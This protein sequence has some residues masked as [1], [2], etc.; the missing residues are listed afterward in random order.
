MIK[1]FILD[2]ETSAINT[3]TLMLKRYVPEIT[4]IQSS[5]QPM[6]AAQSIHDFLPHL[7][8]LDIQMPVIN[9]FEWL[10]KF[11]SPTFEVIFTTAHDNYAIQAIRFSALD[12]LL[13]P[14]TAVELRAAVNRFIEKQKLK[15]DQ[16][17]LYS[18]LLHNINNEQKN[19]KLAVTT[20]DGCF[21]FSTTEIVRME[22]EG[23]YAQVYFTTRK[24]L[25]VSKPLKDFEELLN[26]HGFIRT[27]KSHL[28]NS[29]YIK[30]I[31]S[32]GQAVLSDGTMIE[33]SRRR[34]SDVIDL[35]KGV[36]SRSS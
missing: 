33:V 2:D 7:V 24:P 21:F 20:T 16:R 13:K 9:G 22:A 19:F 17:Q 25:L 27:H 29:M 35:L 23:S 36:T 6:Q 32:E 31:N 34:K 30:V 12:Y 1:A 28:V 4:Q 10:K 14:I 26:D 18:N 11:P 15:D 8:F 5:I 3:L